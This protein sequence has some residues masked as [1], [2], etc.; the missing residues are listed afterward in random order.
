MSASGGATRL[1]LLEGTLRTLVEQG[2]A[3]TSARS[4][5]TTAGVN[6][7]LIF[8]HFGSVDELLAAACA[9]GAEQRVS[10][11]RERLAAL[12]SLTELLTFARAM[13]AEERAAGQVAVLGQ[14]LAAGQTAPALAAATSAGLAL[15]IGELET[16]LTRLL[17]ATPLAAFADP[18]GLARAA[19][20]SFVGI[21]LYEGVDPEGASRA[22]DSLE[23]LAVLAQALEGFG[24]LSQRAVT[25]RLRRRTRD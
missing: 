5:A 19:A 14:L 21:E 22:L 4:I 6:Q 24:P 16:V 17:A 18:A 3:K 10:R 7:A 2:I 15:W 1:K 23:Q 25:H 8:Y 11:Y 12:D 13:H 20:A 9:H